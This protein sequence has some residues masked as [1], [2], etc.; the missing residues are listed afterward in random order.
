MRT[1][2]IV[3]GLGAACGNH[4]SLLDSD[5]GGGTDALWDLAP[6]GTEVGIVASPRAIK[7]V[8]DGITAA[9]NLF[10]MD[11][12]APMRPTASALIGALLGAPDATPDAAGLSADKGFAMFITG[13]GVLGIMPV[14]DRDKFMATKHGTRGEVDSLNG[15]TCKPLKSYYVCA[16]T[17]KLFD[18]LGKGSLRGKAAALAGGGGDMELYAPQLPLFGGTGDLAITLVLS[19]GA[20]A[21]R[22]VWT[23]K[24]GGSLGQLAGTVAPKPA[25][26]NASGFVAVDV[27]KLV[28]GLPPVPLAGGIG[29]DAFAN[30]LAGPVTAVIPAGTV[31]IQITAPLKDIAP[32]KTVFEHCKELGQ[33]LDLA[34]QQ[35]PNACRF[36]MQSASVLELEAWIDEAGKALR[37]GAHRDAPV[38]GTPVALTPIGNEL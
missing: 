14:G 37:V 17:D 9:Q 36:R 15:N 18:R 8:L 7:L 33:F 22:G 10:A 28:G 20:I 30:S 2:L 23:G 4:P 21:A 35:P 24:P 13:D 1:W 25:A 34:E 5:S 38:I 6:D 12:F 11:D 29:F 27:G 31:D 26:T 19:P 32:G 16:T 3:L